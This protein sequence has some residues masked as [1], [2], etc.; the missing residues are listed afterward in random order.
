MKQN[1]GLA[2]ALT[3]IAAK[4]GITSAQLCI[5]WVASLGEN[6]IPIPGSSHAN[7][8]AEN[9]AASDVVLSQEEIDAVDEAIR[10]Y[11]IRGDRGSGNPEGEHLNG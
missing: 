6:I 11:P 9:L 2:E 8:A 4:K 10:R 3:T 1:L 7:R 5:A